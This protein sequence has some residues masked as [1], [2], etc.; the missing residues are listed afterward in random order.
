MTC[1]RKKKTTMNEYEITDRRALELIGSYAY[2]LDIPM[3]TRIQIIT[4]IL[5]GV[6]IDYTESDDYLDDYEMTITIGEDN[7]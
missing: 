5:K 1:L 2:D 7:A 6:G 3:E 4:N